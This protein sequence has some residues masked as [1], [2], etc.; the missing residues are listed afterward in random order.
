MYFQ[1][2]LKGISGISRIE[3]EEFVLGGS[4]ILCKW[5][6][7]VGSISPNEVRDQLTDANLFH[8]LNDYAKPLPAGH[9]MKLRGATTYGDAT[10]FI[11]TTSG[12][13]Q[14]DHSAGKNFLFHPFLTAVKFATQNFTTSGFVFSG[15]LVTIGRKSIPFAGFSEEVR[16]LHIYSQY[17]Q[18]H[19]EG[20]V[21]AKI[22]IPSN[23][24]ECAVE[25]DGPNAKQ[26]LSSGILPT[27]ISPPIYN[28]HYSDPADYCNIRELL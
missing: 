15:F 11:S 28:Q 24:I 23:Q 20:E 8:H 17:L 5:W 1:K 16:E 22:E 10:P 13:I 4:G 18:Y 9:P 21:A 26:A 7:L 27:P 19:H 14:Q 6:K 2:F 3:A 25:F 12:A